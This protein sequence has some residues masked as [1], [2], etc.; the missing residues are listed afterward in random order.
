MTTDATRDKAAE[1]LAAL[2]DKTPRAY[3]DWDYGRVVAFKEANAKARRVSRNARAS[4]AAIQEQMRAL[5]HF[6]GSAAEVV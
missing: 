6:H 5:E 1:A 2:C 4:A 3:P